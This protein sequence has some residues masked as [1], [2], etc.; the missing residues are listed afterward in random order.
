MTLHFN[1]MDLIPGYYYAEI[2]FTSNPNVGSP[3]VNVTLHV[4][5]LIPPNNLTLSY[6]CTNVNLIW[7]MPAGGTPDSWNVYRDG[8]LLGNTTVMNYTNPMVNPG[9]EYGYYVKAVYAG[10]ESMPTATKTITVPL[11][12]NLVATG[13]QALAN[14]PNENDVTLNWNAPTACVAPNGYNVYKDGNQI[15]TALV[16]ALTYVDPNLGAGL[17]EYIVKAVYYFGQSNASNPAYALITGIEN[18][19]TRALMVFPNPASTE[20]IIMSP[21]EIRNIKV[22]NNTGQLVR[23][24]DVNAVQYRMDVSKFESGIYYI[25]L[26]TSDGVTLKK[27]TVN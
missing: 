3:V 21:V 4:E 27:I 26:E 18:Y 23:D 13:L 16:T 17:Y 1:A 8:A 15:N 11:P 24:T 25:K 12:T 5:G 7:Q 6:T 2:H 14:V 9:V 19:D 20:V 22:L 10:V